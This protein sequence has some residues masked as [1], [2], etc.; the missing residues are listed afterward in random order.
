LGVTVQPLKPDTFFAALA[1]RWVE[2]DQ[3]QR[4]SRQARYI[5]SYLQKPQ[6]DA[7]CLLIE[8][9][10]V[11]GDYL[12]DFSSFYV[13]SFPPYQRYCKRLHFFDKSFSQEELNNLLTGDDAAAANALQ[14]SYVGF[15]VVRPLP[16]AII[17]RTVLRTYR[18]NTGE[19][20]FP[21]LRTYKPYL[22]GI[23]LS[24]RSL[25][26]EEQDS[27]VAACATVALWSSF[28]KTHDLFGT[29]RPR[30]AAITKSANFVRSLSRAMPSG[31]LNPIQ[32]GEAIRAAGLEPEFYGLSPGSPFASLVYAY[33][34]AGLPIILGGEVEQHGLHAI[35]I[36]GYSSPKQVSQHPEPP[37][38]EVK[39]EPGKQIDK[40]YVHDD[41][42]G[43]FASYAIVPTPPNTRTITGVQP[44][45]VLQSDWPL[46][47]AIP[48]RTNSYFM[49]EW[50]IIPAYPKIRVGYLSMREWIKRLSSL[51][52][53]LKAPFANSGINVDLVTWDMRL[54]MVNEFKS[55]L[56]SDR[57]NIS[58]ARALS[59][60]PLP[61]FMWRATML[62]D[63]TPTW[64]LLF[65]ATDTNRACPLMHTLWLDGTHRGVFQTMFRDQ[66]FEATW[67]IPLTP[68]FYDALK[69]GRA[70]Y[71]T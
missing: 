38:F 32:I 68:Q 53:I 19:R 30:P 27:S 2:A 7:K 28:H 42:I 44:P 70:P 61:R 45:V 16:Q 22:N 21:T 4:D 3:V 64:L 23:P 18:D 55:H 57:W 46:R 58:D 41:G 65:D 69:N 9:G 63:G 49:P 47:S 39:S 24:I 51:L 6:V 67:R 31:G 48:N 11:D 5:L 36:T 1:N 40:L 20:F 54:T 50:L 10:Y 52:F 13:S 56:R 35:T 43:P 12:E 14:D 33:V 25:A 62:I 8:E 34:S 59:M 29:L 60:E 71:L 66:Q 26:F 37:Y 17:G 15:T